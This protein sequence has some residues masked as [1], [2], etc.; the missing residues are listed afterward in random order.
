MAVTPIYGIPYVESSD[1]VAD[2]PTVSENLAE[3][4]EDKLP[5][6]AATAPTSPNAGQIWIDS[7]DDV[8]YFY[9]GTDWVAFPSGVGNADFSDAATGTYTDSGIDYKFITYTGSGTVTITEAG[10][11][12]VLVVGGGGSG[13]PGGAGAGGY[14][15][16]SGFYLPIGTFSVTIGAGG[17]S[18]REGNYSALG[19]TLVAGGGAGGLHSDGNGSNAVNGS[20]GWTAGSVGGTSTFPSQGNNGGAGATLSAGNVSGGGGG[21]ADAAGSDGSGV[22]GG[23]GGAGKSSSITGTAVTR[24][25]GGGGRAQGSGS[26]GGTGGAG[27]GGNGQSTTVAGT[28]GAANT[29]GGSGGNGGNG[30]SGVVIIR[31]RTN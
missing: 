27:G 3:Q 15:E 22:T 21:G 10:L 17:A 4:V 19:T 30:G 14:N 12:D 18:F 23:N 24:A 28:A 13:E 29:G 31:V 6:Y 2:Y 9:D 20:G 25:G 11:C 1:L 5:T 16:A 7:D 26:T 8:P